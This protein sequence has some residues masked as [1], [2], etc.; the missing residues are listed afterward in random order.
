M[1]KQVDRRNTFIFYSKKSFGQPH[2][3]AR[4]KY[5]TPNEKLV[6]L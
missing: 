4:G 6:A 1:S 2:T 5:E 3:T